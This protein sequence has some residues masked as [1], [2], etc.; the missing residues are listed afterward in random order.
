MLEQ[1]TEDGYLYW[2]CHDEECAGL[3][4]AHI[5]DS[6]VEYR[7][8]G[9]VALPPCPECGSQHFRKAEY[10]LKELLKEQCLLEVRDGEG[11]QSGYVLKA[12]H[13]RNF[14]LL[15]MLYEL[16]KMPE[17]PLLRVL[18]LDVIRGSALAHLPLEVVDAIWLPY[19][20]LGRAITLQGIDQHIKAI[21][22]AVVPLIAERSMSRG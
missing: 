1:V 9:I 15:N 14:R 19:L 8:T 21:G 20:L 5:T 12:S 13:A 16:G 6:G 7:E 10:T 2:R 22:G 3:Q 11:E 18:S 4:R 17:P